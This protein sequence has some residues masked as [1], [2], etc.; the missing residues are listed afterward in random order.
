MYPIVW[1]PFGFPISSFGVMLAIAFLVGTWI[2]AI[3]M[4]E[5]GLN[6]ELAT[7][8][9]LYVMLGGVG[10]AKL[11][12]AIDNSLREGLPFFPL[13]I[14]RDG[15]LHGY[16]GLI[17]GTLVGLLGC[18]IHKL[19]LKTVADCTAVAG[20]V[21]QALG[22]V[23]CFLVG[24]DYGRVTDVPWGLAFP[25]G[26]PRRSTRCI[27]RRSMKSPGSCRLPR[28]WW[29]RRHRSPFLF[30]EYVALNGVGRILIEHWRVNPRVALGLTE[31]QWIGIALVI[32]GASGW[33]YY[34]GKPEPATV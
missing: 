31:P 20:A 30:G 6:P 23:G 24:D 25:K 11:Y 34:R 2:T 10:G 18:R 22:R 19:P 16:G 8:I 1:E 17:G 5:E 3:R 28:S 9:L 15:G 29:R 21:G 7:T 33:M 32:L 26:S 13:L 4:R 12:F 14:A 27:L